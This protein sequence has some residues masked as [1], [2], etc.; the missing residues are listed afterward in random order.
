MLITSN[1]IAMK[2]SKRP[3]QDSDDNIEKPQSL[4]RQV[5]EI[6]CAMCRESAT[7]FAPQQLARKERGMHLGCA[8]GENPHYFHEDCLNSW[9]TGSDQNHSQ[10]PLC[11]QRLILPPITFKEIYNAIAASELTMLQ[12]LI[13]RTNINTRDNRGGTALHYA[14]MWRNITIMEW[15]LTNNADANIQDVF[16]DTALHL[17]ADLRDNHRCINLLLEKGANPNIVNN[18]G[19]SP[20]YNAAV[21][22]DD[23]SIKLLLQNEA[24]I[25][26]QN[27]DGSTP[28]SIAV[29]LKR[30]NAA[31]TL[32]NCGANFTLTNN[33]GKDALNLAIK[34]G[35]QDIINTINSI[36]INTIYTQLQA[37][38][39]DA[40]ITQTDRSLVVNNNTITFS[41]DST[42]YNNRSIDIMVSKNTEPLQTYLTQT[43][44]ATT[45]RLGL[46]GTCWHLG[47]SNW[48]LTYRNASSWFKNYSSH[49]HIKPNTQLR[50]Y[51]SAPDDTN[52]KTYIDFCVGLAATAAELTPE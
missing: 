28:L 7:E 14:T 15:L 34:Q 21:K 38:F 47:T 39:P 42:H 17:A 1:L 9:L 45:H 43:L 2:N 5:L 4:K 41:F 18:H 16:G 23:R 10:C 24:D 11:K 36:I 32:L 48:Q 3:R 37:Q 33:Q 13:E 26:C 50:F 35:A 20:L 27:N 52:L 8:Q 29:F 19:N 25:N 49:A 46:L 51:L 31:I 40:T 44:G 6:E 12:T 22:G 30:Y